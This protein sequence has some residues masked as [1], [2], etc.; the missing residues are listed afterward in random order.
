MS[1]SHRRP[2]CR[3]P[4][5]RMPSGVTARIPAF[6]LLLALL[7]VGAASGIACRDAEAPAGETGV[8]ASKPASGDQLF[9]EAFADRSSGLAVEG[10]GTVE[11]LLSDDT[12]GSRHQRFIVRLASGQTLLIAHN[13]DIAPRVEGLQV[14][15]SVAFKGEYE[16]NEQGGLVH[17]THRDPDGDHAAG[18]IEHDGKTYQ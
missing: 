11:R 13:V 17:W 12:D 15:D 9:G 14:G 6:V 4:N 2:T 10:Q 7:A 3:P 16:W 1:P 5:L 18:W 8:T